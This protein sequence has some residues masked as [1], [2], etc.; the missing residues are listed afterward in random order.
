MTLERKFVLVIE[1]DPALR[2]ALVELLSDEGIPVEAAPNGKTALER[3]RA[4]L[5]PAAILLD[6]WMPEMD[7]SSFR[8]EQ[9]SDAALRDIPIAVFTGSANADGFEARFPDVETIRK[10]VNAAQLVDVVR[11]LA[12]MSRDSEA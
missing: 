5:R 10:P 3:L 12:R 8:S 2:D 6:L 4:G 9:L 1:D 11:R 7:G